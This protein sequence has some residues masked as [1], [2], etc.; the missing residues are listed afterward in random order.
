MVQGFAGHDF[1]VLCLFLVQRIA[2]RTASIQDIDFTLC[3]FT[4]CN[5]KVHMEEGDHDDVQPVKIDFFP[6]PPI[7][8]SCNPCSKPGSCR[9]F[10]T[11]LP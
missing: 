11:F 7:I 2:K 6:V 10:R 4:N 9:A 8:G 3:I 1:G 5:W